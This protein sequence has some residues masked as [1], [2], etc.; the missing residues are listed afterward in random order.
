LM[1]ET[2]R[3]LS[4]MFARIRGTNVGILFFSFSFTSA[5]I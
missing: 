5:E 2:K 3:Q 1:P 4:H